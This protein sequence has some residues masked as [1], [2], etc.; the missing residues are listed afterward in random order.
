MALSWVNTVNTCIVI[1]FE[2]CPTTCRACTG[3]DSCQT[4]KSPFVLENNK[5]GCLDGQ[6]QSGNSCESNYN[7]FYYI[8]L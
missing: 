2:E 8:Y 1:Y 5:C 3:A 6:Y 4:C 7:N